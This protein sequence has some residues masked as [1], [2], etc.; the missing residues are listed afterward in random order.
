MSASMVEATTTTIF[1]AGSIGRTHGE[2]AAWEV[3]NQRSWGPPVREGATEGWQPGGGDDDGDL[4]CGIDRPDSRRGCGVGSQ[5]SAFLGTPG[6]GGRDGGLATGYMKAVVYA[7]TRGSSL[8][9]GRR[10]GRYVGKARAVHIIREAV[11]II[12]IGT[13]DFLENYYSYV[14]G[15][16]REFKVEEFED[17]LI[18][19][20]ADF[21]TAIYTV[22]ARKISFTGLGAMGCLPLER[23]TNALHGG[24]CIEEYNKVARDFNVK[25][26]P[27][28]PP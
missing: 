28:E 21:L 14:T 10:L 27:S 16:F 6:Q 24:D 15:R 2:G 11:Y 5:E 1:V 25:L 8:P 26:D 17:F 23:T 22:G 20:A 13:N 12:S 4:R 9:H 18:D 3:K 19:R 7:A